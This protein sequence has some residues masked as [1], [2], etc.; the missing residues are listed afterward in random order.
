MKYFDLI[1]AYYNGSLT[2]QD[3]RDFEEDVDINPDLKKEWEEYKIA[4]QVAG[5][6][7]F[8]AAK[9]KISAL[10]QT[11]LTVAHK[12]SNNRIALRIAAAVLVLVVSGFIF[13]QARYSDK[14]IANQYFQS[15]SQSMRSPSTDGAA[16]LIDDGKYEEA[17]AL[18]S[19]APQDPM[20]KSLLAEVY[21]K[22]ERYPEAIATYREL[23]NT[24][25]YLNRD[26]AEFA[27]AVV[28][29]KSGDMDASHKLLSEIATNDAH[30]YRFEAQEMLEKMDSFWRKLVI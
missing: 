14:A 7:A 4:R 16:K 8:D 25:D 1:E 26:G 18:L 29:M 28:L 24:P 13:S 6:F 22:L 30:D 20:T 2:A 11:H 21:T 15:T 27:L 10:R 12:G 9:R 5:V 19:N 23:I 3:A 17:I